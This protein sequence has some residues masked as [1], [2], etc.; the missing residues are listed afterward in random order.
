MADKLTQKLIPFGEQPSEPLPESHVEA[1]MYQPT[2]E[3]KGAVE[4]L[5]GW[6]TNPRTGRMTEE[7]KTSW[8]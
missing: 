5:E 7:R 6:L 3:A 4:R 8:R 1:V 2:Q